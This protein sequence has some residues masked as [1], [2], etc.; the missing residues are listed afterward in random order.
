MQD[1]VN[2][3]QTADSLNDADES[4]EMTNKVD[5]DRLDSAQL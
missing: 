5:Q 4:C 3:N 2:N 1:S